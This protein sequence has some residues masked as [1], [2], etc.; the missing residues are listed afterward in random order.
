MDRFDTACAFA[1]ALILTGALSGCAAYRKCG[2]EGCPG[3]AK[4]TAE[5]ST[6]L[7]QHPELVGANSL[8]VQTLD[9]EVYLNGLVDTPLQRET[10]ESIARQAPRVAGVVNMIAVNNEK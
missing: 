3:D 4:I 9:H 8:Y 5:V 6:L 7:N 10:A 1:A 2:F